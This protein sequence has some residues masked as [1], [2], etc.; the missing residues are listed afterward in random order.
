M[1]AA[2]HANVIALGDN[3]RQAKVDDDLD[4]DVR[5]VREQFH[6]LRLKDGVGR[7]FVAVMRMVPAGLSRSSLTAASLSL[8]L[9]QSAARQCRKQAFAGFRRRDAARRARQKPNPQA[10]FEPADR[11]AQG[12]LRHAKLRRRLREAALSATATNARRSLRCPR[13]IYG[14]RS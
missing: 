11:V 9:A 5:I 10:R 2:T 12:R 3:I 1:I 14:L 4:L 6:Q 13:C 8:D 7:I